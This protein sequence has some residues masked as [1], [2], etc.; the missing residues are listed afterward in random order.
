MLYLCLFLPASI[1][2]L[3]SEKLRKEKRSVRD[4]VLSYL[5]YT[6]IITA[7][8]NTIVYFISSEKMFWYRTATFTYDFC[9]KYMW[10]SLAVAV[11]LPCLFHIISKVV[12]INIEVK[13][14]KQDVKKDNKSISENYKR[15]H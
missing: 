15:K 4:L 2:I 9:L 10:L 7:I 12:Q 11:V 8:M 5:G 3:V 1:S 13:E 6:F 14:K